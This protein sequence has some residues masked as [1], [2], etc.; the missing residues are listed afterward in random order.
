MTIAIKANIYLHFVQATTTIGLHKFLEDS[1]N[2]TNCE[3]LTKVNMQHILV[4]FGQMLLVALV[5]IAIALTAILITKIFP[6]PNRI[7]SLGSKAQRSIALCGIT[8]GVIYGLLFRLFSHQSYNQLGPL[9]FE[10]VSVS[11]LVF[12]PIG[13]GFFTVLLGDLEL[14]WGWKKSIIIPWTTASLALGATFLLAWEGL[15]C[16]VLFLPMFLICASIGGLVGHLANKHLRRPTSG[17]KGCLCVT[18]FILPLLSTA[19]EQK[20]GPTSQTRTVR[21]TI[22]IEAAP[23]IVWSEIKSVRKIDDSE[24]SFYLAHLIGF[25]KPVAADL[26]GEGLGSV[27]QASFEGGVVFTETVNEWRLNQSIAFSI[28]ANTDSIPPGTL[29]QHVTIGGP[30]FDVLNGRYEIKQMAENKVLLELTSQHRLSTTFNFY[31]GM[32]TDFIMSDIQGYILR[33]IKMRCLDRK[34]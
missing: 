7:K 11:F 33:I 14:N 16:I 10:V 6:T 3:S 12:V 34:T 19:I 28:K 29:D 2:I 5:L 30:F 1:K 13:M 23:T 4:F 24:H 31:S 18:G 17:L 20:I 21:S 27:R 9:K 25:P 8:A 26:I 15:I 22:E 32:W